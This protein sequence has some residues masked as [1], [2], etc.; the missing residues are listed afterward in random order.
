MATVT[1][2][3]PFAWLKRKNR[4]DSERP[5]YERKDSPTSAAWTESPTAVFVVIAA[6]VA[7]VFA[8]IAV[9]V[10]DAAAPPAAF[11]LH[12]LSVARVAGVP[13]PASAGASAV[14]VLALRTVCPVAAGTFGPASGSLY[15]LRPD[16]EAAHR[17]AAGAG[18]RQ[19]RRPR[20]FVQTMPPTCT[21]RRARTA[22]YAGNRYAW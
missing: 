7:R 13:A 10:A 1:A 19:R 15:N 18:Q 20:R 22:A 2:L 3:P 17:P 6:V 8:A 12:W 5:E 4:P 16:R 11:L 21:T 9:S 14:P